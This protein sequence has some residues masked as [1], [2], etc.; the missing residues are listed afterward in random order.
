MWSEAEKFLKKDKY[1][2]PL[3]KKYGPITSKKKPKSKYFESLVRAIVGQQLSIKAAAT[4]YGRLEEKAGVVT[5][6]RILK[7]RKKTLRGCGLSNAKSEYIKDLAKHVISGELEIDRLKD[8]TDEKVMEE[9]VA[10]K[11]IG[12]WTAEMFL[13]FTL[14]R[15]DVFSV[16]DLGLVNGV[17]KILKRRLEGE[18]LGK[19]AERWK[20]HRTAAAWYVWENLDN[21]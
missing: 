19:F 8:L 4:I 17:K 6:E 1:I 15:P 5:P 14:G 10:V 2:G 21:K 11:G 18:K 20:P 12:K 3:I 7:L 9:L 16:M 13:M